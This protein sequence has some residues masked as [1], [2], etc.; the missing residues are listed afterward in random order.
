LLKSCQKIV[1]KLSKSWQK[2]GKKLVTIQ[3]RVGEGE[4]GGEEEG[5][6]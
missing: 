5:D 2:I 4:E 6:L 3:K 1:I